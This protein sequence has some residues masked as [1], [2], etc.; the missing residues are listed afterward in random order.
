MPVR[1]SAFH[2]IGGELNYTCLGT[3]NYE[4]TLKVYRDCSNSNAAGFDDPALIAV[5]DA[6]AFLV[7]QLELS[8]PGYSNVE[9]DNTNPCLQIPPGICVEYAIYKT[10]VFLPPK[11]GGY[12]LAYQR[13]CRNSSIVNIIDPDHEG[14]TY[15]AHIPDNSIAVCNSNPAFKNYPPIVICVDQ[16]LIIDQSAT[17]ADGDSLVYSLCSP[18][19]G[20]SYLMPIPN[21]APP[22][23]YDTVVW[24]PPFNAS[25]P[26]GGNPGMQI[27]KVTGLLTAHPEAIGQY[28]V[29]VCVSEY[30]N[31]VLLGTHVRDF[32]FNITSCDPLVL[33]NFKADEEQTE[34]ADTLLVCT[35][36]TVV[37]Q[38]FSYGSNDFFWD[39]GIEGVSGD[40]SHETNPSYTFPDTGLYK[41]TLI[42][43]PGIP[44]GD[45]TYRYIE[46]RRGVS[47][48]FTFKSFCAYTPVPFND[49][50]SSQ[51]GYLTQW[52][53]NFGDGQS[54]SGQNPE[55]IFQTPGFFPVTL[56]VNDNHGCSAD[57]M[58]QVSVDPTP[59]VNAH[60]DTFVCNIDTV[61]LHASG[62]T[63][64]SWSPF[65]N[66]N[67]TT[68]ANPLVNPQTTTTYFVTV[69]N[70][71]G[72]ISRDSVMVRVT[73]TV[74]AATSPDTIIC[75]GQSI[76][77]SANNAVYYRWS[78]PDGLSSTIISNPASTPDAT[79]TYFVKSYI[80]SCV[81]EDTIVISVLPVPLP[82]AG[83]DVTIN[84]GDTTQLHGS[85]GA[86]YQWDPPTALSSSATAEPQANPLA[87]TQYS[88]LVT[89]ENGCSS[90]DEVTVDVTHNHLIF[91][92]NAF[93]PNG[94]GIND[95]FQFYSKGIAQILQVQVFNRW[96]ELVFSSHGETPFW[97]GTYK[98]Q[99]CNL[100]TYI[101]QIT[102]ESYDGNVIAEKGAVTLIR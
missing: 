55:H 61:M 59:N 79:T 46:I 76:Q 93:T 75:Q 97:D 54:S 5:Y 23:P 10:T 26:V 49:L 50:S 20:A 3:Y 84:Q 68:F 51:D 64:Y 7:T 81:D 82:E 37:F 41:V 21:P 83:P 19:Q 16:P 15:Y 91:V 99:P 33:A 74:I 35:V 94:D 69:I 48:D 11:A 80:G 39:F 27:D 32:Q 63:V 100:D 22:P 25:N 45:T 71:E 52:N 38:N 36:G 24:V 31:G 34:K 85:G 66:I 44:C 4:I 18:F 65:Q 13:C 30:R 53:W 62:G 92:P 78:P 58:K 95:L 8:L 12:D 40:T 86:L 60:P 47:A 2:I 29:G 88:L 17:D 1:T 57:I 98:G 77:L 56:T 67:D 6:N 89:G 70:S 14:A 96:G 90:K 42:A 43:S 72:C 87:S 101:Y 28:V 102:G 73:D 9:P